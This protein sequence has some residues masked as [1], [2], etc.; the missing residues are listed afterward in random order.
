MLQADGSDSR[1]AALALSIAPTVT[2]SVSAAVA[3][4]QMNSPSSEQVA[5]TG[6]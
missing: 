5:E 4:R 6:P 2:H 1:F 3:T